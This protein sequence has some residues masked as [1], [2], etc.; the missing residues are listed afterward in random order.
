MNKKEIASKLATEGYEVLYGKYEYWDSIPCV[1][2]T[3]G[4]K[5][6]IAKTYN[7]MGSAGVDLD[8]N[9]KKVLQAIEIKSIDINNL[10]ST[11]ETQRI[12][13]G[14]EKLII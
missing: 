11:L 12:E 9:Y 10:E 2:H 14:V 6:F 5:T 3:D 8:L 4:S 1:Q 7:K 13:K